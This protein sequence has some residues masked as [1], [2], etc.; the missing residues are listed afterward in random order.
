MLVS[1][2]DINTS[3]PN[4]DAMRLHA[5]GADV[6]NPDQEGATEESGKPEWWILRITASKAHYFHCIQ[7]A[8]G[9]HSVP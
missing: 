4:Q 6:L 1:K 7:A 8:A 9:V 5:L 3:L 2:L